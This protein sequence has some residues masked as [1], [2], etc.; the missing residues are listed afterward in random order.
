M[1]LDPKNLNLVIPF[2]NKRIFH[3]PISA[4][5]FELNY[6]IL[7]ATKAAIFQR[8]IAY[9]IDAGPIIATLRLRDEAAKDA[10]ERME[11]G[12]GGAQAL[13]AEIKRLTTVLMPTEAGWETV[14]VDKGLDKDEWK[15]VEAA[16]VFFT[17]FF[18][19]ARR[20]QRRMIADGAASGLGGE[21]TSE[22]LSQWIASSPPV[23]GPPT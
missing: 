17:S 14:P 12:D 6:R 19:M 1:D 20:S 3:T 4:D 5:V 18:W 23:S 11:E 10:K 2:G 9:A 13:L 21:I 15:E 16:L 8:G 22:P 7:S